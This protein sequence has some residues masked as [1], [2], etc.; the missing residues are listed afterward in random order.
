[1][2]VNAPANIEDLCRPVFTCFCNYWQLNQAGNPPSMETFRGDIE[3]SLEDAKLL[4]A[5]DPALNREYE[6]IE[7]PL[8]FFIDFMVKE[9]SFPFSRDWRELGRN[10]NELSGDE[11]FFNLLSDALLDSK[12]QNII[13]L[14]YTMLGLGFEGAYIQDHRFIEKTM[15][16]C[17]ARFPG[18]LDIR[19][20]PIVRIAVEKR[21]AGLK[22]GRVLRSLGVVLFLSVLLL[23]VSLA[24]N[25]SVFF[26]TT[27]PFRETLSGAAAQAREIQT[28][29]REVP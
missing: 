25:F 14:F 28:I 15:K 11:K 3:S 8:V 21:I 16:E 10:Y 29:P 24:V 5:S 23:I 9:G 26:E 1:M 20:E 6:G 13:P 2:P 4:A 19:E 18:E 17:A 12:A 7:R 27:R 22:K